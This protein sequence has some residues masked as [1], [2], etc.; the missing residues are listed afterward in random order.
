VSAN[1]PETAADAVEWEDPSSLPVPTVRELFLTL[2]KTLRSYQLYDRNNPVYLRFVANLREAFERVWE[3]R[4]DLQIMVEEDRFV[5]MG[6]EVYRDENRSSSLCFLVYRDGIRDLTLRR[7]IEG[8]EI[9]TLLDVLHRVRSAARQEEDDLVTLLWD[10]DLE[11]L[12]YGAVDLLPEG[13]LLRA[14]GEGDPSALDVR[15]ILQGELGTDLPGDGAEA[16][17]GDEAPPAATVMDHVRAIRP[18]DFNPTLYALDEGE[19]G[20]LEGEYRKEMDRDVRRDVLYALFDRLE[21]DHATPGR[22]EEIVACLHQLLPGFLGQGRLRHAALLL[23]ELEALT[24]R[25]GKLSEGA[26]R[27][28]ESLLEELS[29]EDAVRELVQAMEDGAVRPEGDDLALLLRFLRPAALGPLLARAEE[30]TRAEVRKVIADAIRALAKGQEERLERFL[31]DP[32]PSVV[33]GAVRLLGSLGHR[34]ASSHLVRL[35]EEGEPRVQQAV[36]EAARRIPTSQLAASL[37]RRLTGDDRSL[38]IGAARVLAEI[39]YTPATA[40]LRRVLEG[41]ELRAAD[42]S[43]QMAFFSAFADLAGADGVSLLERFLHHRSLLGRRETPE[44]R[45]CAALALGRI[46]GTKAVELLRRAEGDDDP[47]VRSAVKRALTEDRTEA[48]H[49]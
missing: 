35:L 19:R 21:H 12:G 40:T 31:S 37:E 41:R 36:L 48:A 17:G 27:E 3:T 44:I 42:L 47:V 22:Q 20:Y 28:V 11:H 38:R 46:G 4:D 32:D 24:E 29:S 45:A 6:E 34:G 2:S 9:E 14:D 5:W 13:T 1:P 7:G 16:S 33:T 10:L 25:E 15:G 30:V 23:R 39:R 18:E 49:G 8:P 26:L 43:E